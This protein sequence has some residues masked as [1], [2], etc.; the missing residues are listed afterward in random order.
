ME[1]GFAALLAATLLFLATHIG[2]SSTGLRPALVKRVGAGGFL[3]LYS[4]VA[5]GTIV[6]MTIAYR[7]APMVALWHA[8][9]GVR[10][11]PFALMPIAFV[12][13][14]AGL[15]TRNPASV[16]QDA[17]A[18]A[19]VRGI[20]RI[21][22]HPVQWAILIWALLH[23]IANGDLASLV[24]FGGFAILAAAGGA[25]IDAKKRVR[26]GSEWETFARATSNVPFA[27]IAQGRNRVSFYEVGP[28]RVLGGLLLFA[29]LV[30]AHPYLFGVSA[31]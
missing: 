17:A 8:G 31:M 26:L 4:L 5:L 7:A 6:W 29:I 21:T 23:V 3:A 25:L 9:E 15:T 10:G 19:P 16:G 13:L 28:W 20:L 14:L 1:S 11:L 12:L 24:F 22:R 27:A 2:L 30:A 18:A